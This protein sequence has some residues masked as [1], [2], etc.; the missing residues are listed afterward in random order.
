MPHKIDVSAKYTVRYASGRRKPLSYWDSSYSPVWRVSF[1]LPG[2]MSLH[3]VTTRQLAIQRSSNS[4]VKNVRR[5]D[6]LVKLGPRPSL[7]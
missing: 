7:I 5:G 4:R 6:G 1:Y 2:L 3:F